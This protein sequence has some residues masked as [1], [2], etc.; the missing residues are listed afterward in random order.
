[1]KIH[2]QLINYQTMSRL[3]KF[4]EGIAKA[5]D[6]LELN[7]QYLNKKEYSQRLELI[8]I[9]EIQANN[10][11]AEIESFALKISYEDGARAAPYKKSLNQINERLTKVRGHLDLKK[12]EH[13]TEGILLGKIIK[14]KEDEGNG[15]LN[16]F[17]FLNKVIEGN[18]LIQVEDVLVQKGLDSLDGA[19]V[20]V[21]ATHATADE[22]TLELHGQREKS[23]KTSVAIN[24]TSPNVKRIIS[25]LFKPWCWIILVA[26]VISIIAFMIAFFLNDYDGT[27]DVGGNG[28]L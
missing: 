23:E 14:M 11:D 18:V 2:K 1:M 4:K 21:K 3:D 13:E 26:I 25:K 7:I 10:I 24:K 19:S 17:W 15:K 6:D 20:K 12:K 9:C 16:D 22:I 5:L 28:G 8:K 27:D